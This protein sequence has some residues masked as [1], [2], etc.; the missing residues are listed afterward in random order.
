MPRLFVLSGADRGRTVDVDGPVVLGRAPEAD[1]RLRSNAVSRAHAKLAPGPDGWTLEDLGSSNGTRVDGATLTGTVAIED[2]AVFQV[3]DVELRFRAEVP[4][5]EAPSTE[6]TPPQPVAAPEPEVELEGA[7]AEIELE[8]E[9]DDDADASLPLRSGP[10]HAS[11]VRVA[12]RKLA[13]AAR[14][15]EDPKPKPKPRPAARRE[16]PKDLPTGRSEAAT[17]GKPVLQY[18]RVERRSGLFAADLAQQPWYLRWGLYLVAGLLFAALAYGAFTLVQGV[19]G[20]RADVN[21]PAP[22]TP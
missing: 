11:D 12:S 17:L 2:G 19:K 8:G 21:A 5:A 1:V 20:T 15:D 9:W 16:R 7:P 13:D 3:G 14:G 22:S 10:T 4:Q 6:A 18:Q